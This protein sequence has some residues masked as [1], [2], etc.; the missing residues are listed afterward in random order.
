VNHLSHSASVCECT[1]HI[2][3]EHFFAVHSISVVAF[4]LL[5]F[6]VCTCEE[7]EQE[8]GKSKLREG[9]GMRREQDDHSIFSI[10]T[11]YQL[12]NI[13]S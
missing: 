2:Y 10:N 5:P 8:R 9:E 6:A 13:L 1:S 11:Q 12:S 7:E 4:F 3:L